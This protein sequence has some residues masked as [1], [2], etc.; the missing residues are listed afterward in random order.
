[1]PLSRLRHGTSRTQAAPTVEYGSLE[2]RSPPWLRRVQGDQI[3]LT[4]EDGTTGQVDPLLLCQF[5]LEECLKRGVRLHHPATVLS[6]SSD[7][8]GELSGARIAD[9]KSGTVTDLPCTRVIVAA[10]AWSGE[11]FRNLFPHSQLKS[12]VLSYAGHSIVVKSPRW[13][14]EQDG[15]SHALFTT[16]GDGFSPEMFSRV[17]GHIY[18]AGLNS[19]TIPLPEVPGKSPVHP[20]AIARLKE[21]SKELLGPPGSNAGGEDDLEVIR[22][23]LW[24]VPTTKKNILPK[25]R[26]KSVRW[27]TN[28]SFRPVMPWGTPV[29]SRISD[30]DLGVG[31]TTRPGAD[32][33]VYIATGHGPWG[34]SMSLGTGMVLAE[35]V[36]GRQPSADISGVGLKTK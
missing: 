33:G 25:R 3:E 15:E 18:V 12:P 23:G 11:V 20:E 24:Y 34:I 1:M 19:S 29:I 21:M 30:A 17:N 32:G 36:Q 14:G 27:L 31:M 26:V 35:T 6:V 9:D 4:S 16:H 7:V 22:E 13:R 10:G 8:R 2:G 5:L 28:S